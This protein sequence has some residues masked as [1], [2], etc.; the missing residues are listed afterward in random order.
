MLTMQGISKVFQVGQVLTHALRSIDLSVR[1]GDFLA[2]TGPSGSGKSTLLNVLGLLEGFSSGHYQ[3]DG[4]DVR[5]LGDSALSALRNEKIG[6]VFQAFNLIPDLNVQANVEVPLRYRGMPTAERRERVAA[7]LAKVG[8]GSRMSHF[9]GE[10]SG[11]QQQRVAI[12]RAFAGGPALLLADEPT[13]NL[14][15]EMAEAVM[16]ILL[17]LNAEGMTIIMV[18]HD[19]DLA[20]R[21]GRTISIVDGQIVEVTAPQETVP[22]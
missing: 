19:K 15:T 6:F 22:A 2:I 16:N 7:A 14:D 3:I 1:S 18:T 10:L 21:A 5:G 4:V 11:G 12:A 13:G 8:L 20:S 9:P 17:A